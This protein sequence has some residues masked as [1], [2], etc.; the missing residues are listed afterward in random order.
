M[1]E[2]DEVDFPDFF[3]FFFFLSLPPPRHPISTMT[4]PVSSH[5]AAKV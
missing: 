3:F 4:T 5:N 1:S 2:A